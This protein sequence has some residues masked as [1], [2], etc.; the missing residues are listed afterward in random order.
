MKRYIRFASYIYPAAWRRRYATE[1]DAMLD[2]LDADWHDVFDTLKGAITMQFTFWNLRTITLTFA[3]IGVAIA[4]AVAFGIRNQYQ[5]MSVLRVSFVGGT[6]QISTRINAIE[7]EILSRS[8]LQQ[9]I[10]GLGLYESERREKPIEEIEQDMRTKDIRIK[11]VRGPQG[12]P[13]DWMAFSI[14]SVYPD[15]KL[16]RAVNRQLVTKFIEQNVQLARDGQDPNNMEVLDPPSWPQQPLG[17]HRVPLILTGL[18]AGLLLGLIV[19]YS[20]RWRIMIVRR[21]AH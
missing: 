16:A 11:M 20:M 5:S 14:S 4:A 10:T 12:Q 19:S 17:P 3:V 1:F 15:A 18:F 13:N 21:P 9:M 6:A 8:S 2:Q 7:Q